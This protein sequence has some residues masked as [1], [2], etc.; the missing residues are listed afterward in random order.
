MAD[1]TRNEFLNTLEDAF[2]YGI[3][4]EV[5]KRGSKVLRSTVSIGSGENER[6]IA[7]TVNGIGLFGG[8]S[9]Q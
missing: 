2:K 5:F 8:A 3:T 6:V 4:V 7:K 1:G 9:V